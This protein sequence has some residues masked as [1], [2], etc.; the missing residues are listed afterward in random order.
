MR[1]AKTR[2]LEREGLRELAAIVE[3]S[4]D[5]IIGKRL[6]GTITSWNPAAERMY[7]YSA[8]EAVGRPVAM[9][10]P[11]ERSGEVARILERLRAGEAVSD[12]DTV[13]VR[14]DGSRVDVLVTVSPIRDERGKVVG[15]S[16]IAHDLTEFRRLEV[17][18][19]Q[20]S[21]LDAIGRLAAGIAHDFNN[22]L[23][24]IRGYSELL[25]QNVNGEDRESV[26]QIDAA[27][28]RA[29]EFTHQLLAFCRQQVL[30]PEPTHVNEV[31]AETVA[32]LARSLGEDI[33]LETQLGDD[34]DA[35]VVD[36]SEL[37]K[38]IL[39]LAINAR[40][41]M[42]AGGTLRIR[43]SRVDLDGAAP[44]LEVQAGPYVVLEV[45]DTGIG[46][47]EEVRSRV[48]DPFF[49][50]KRDGTGLGL[51]GV[52]GLARQSGGAVVL[53]SE[54]GVGST[55]T[56]YFPVA[57]DVPAPRVPDEPLDTLN[58]NEVILLVEDTEMVR[59]LVVATLESYGYEVLAA[60]GAEEALAIGRRF[61]RDIDLLLTDVV[62]PGING[63]ELAERLVASRPRL[64]VLFTSGYPADMT[65]R[66]GVGNGRAA[67]IE[68]PYLPE[69]LARTVRRVLDGVA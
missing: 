1:I 52:Y 11:P 42:P 12:F 47:P 67:F 62:I 46:M 48:F 21:K 26:E 19:H 49:T 37:A 51:A 45:R 63:H 2:H 65:L 64:K 40:D 56:L 18:L 14:K 25:L 41:A 36:R 13:R 22:L 66:L 33:Q 57:A 5:A 4:N 35:I 20:A 32:L 50:T 3:G 39:N 24:V 16:T 60:S 54:P 58:G 38:A 55:F 61:D 27:A 29:S 30:E 23:I 7:G 43:T 10:E 9:L 44:Q 8:D 53:E 34:L 17:E 68:K 28:R 6:D 69:A 31:V 59:K 15:A